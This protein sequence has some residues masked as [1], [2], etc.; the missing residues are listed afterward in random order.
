M[1][2]IDYNLISDIVKAKEA[3]K[4]SVEGVMDENLTA[5]HLASQVYALLEH[6]DKLEQA[7]RATPPTEQAAPAQQPQ[8][9]QPPQAE[10]ANAEAQ[11]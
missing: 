4:E 10:Q 7:W 11:E 8:E 2:Q 9:E 1:S 6:L 3:V 5:A